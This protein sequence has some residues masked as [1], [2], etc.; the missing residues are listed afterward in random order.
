[1]MPPELPKSI[2]PRRATD[3]KIELL[4][5]AKPPTKALYRMSPLELAEL[6]KKLTEVLDA[7]LV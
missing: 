5:G 1:M 2:P 3:H 6:R 7:G 4:P